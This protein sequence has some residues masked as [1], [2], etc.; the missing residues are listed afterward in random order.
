MNEVKSLLQKSGSALKTFGQRLG[1][2]LTR[3]RQNLHRGWRRFLR[4]FTRWID[5][6]LEP[7]R[8][9]PRPKAPATT[10]QT[11]PEPYTPAST[12]ELLALLR[13]TPDSVLTDHERQNIIAAINF[14]T[15]KV[16]DL[17]LPRADITYVQEDE[18]LGPL[19]LDRLYRSGFQ[20]FPVQDATGK[21]I[22][23][24]HTAAL[25][26]LDTKSTPRAADLIDPELYYL[27]SD[28]TLAQALAAFLRTNCFF[29]LVIDRRSQIVGLLT[30]QML[31]EYL[32]GTVPSD[33]FERDT[34]RA[35]VAKRQL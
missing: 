8:S 10:D 33:T 3:L 35:A 22:G 17:M 26:H 25:N 11:A 29:F 27:R 23:V 2:A 32:L 21:I 20:H 30:Y 12:A 19:T 24:I 15:A 6:K 7:Y 4:R 14:P 16:S 31:I 34:D 18:T 1:Q 5:P 28:Y 9:K 13:R